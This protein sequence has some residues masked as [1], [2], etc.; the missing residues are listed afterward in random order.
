MRS[1][2]FD[3][4][5]RDALQPGARVGDRY[6]VQR[7]VGRG[8]FCDV[9]SAADTHAQGAACAI[10]VPRGERRQTPRLDTRFRLEAHATS[11]LKSPHVATASDFGV[12]DDG[13][14]YFVMELL[15]GLS[16]AGLLARDSRVH[17]Q[18][19]AMIG[20]DVLHAL[21][22]AHGRGIVHRDVKPSNVLLVESHNAPRLYARLIDFGIAKF[23]GAQDLAASPHNLTGPG[24]SPCTPHYA[25]PEQLRDAPEPRS[26]LY[27]LGMLLATLLD[28]RSPYHGLENVDVAEA[29]LSQAPVP[30]GP[31]TRDS[32]LAP[33]IEIACAK[34]PNR[35][36]ASA[37]AMRRALLSAR[38]ELTRLGNAAPLLLADHELDFEGAGTTEEG[39]LEPL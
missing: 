28:G 24:S 21:H 29:H 12:L 31:H 8:A 2:A 39:V 32:A 27:A 19:V 7:R 17:P 34:V 3:F 11:M 16:L 33:V 1:G 9:Y 4:S 37:I 13:R 23:L 25:A 14:P 18:H 26:D 36:F 15:R 10:K 5:A 20:V 6:I 30:L 38:D 35:R 22:E